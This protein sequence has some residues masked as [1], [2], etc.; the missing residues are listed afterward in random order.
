MSSPCRSNRAQSSE[1]HTATQLPAPSVATCGSESPPESLAALVLR[2]AGAVQVAPSSVERAT[3]MSASVPIVPPSVSSEPQTATQFPAP[4]VATC[5][6]PSYPES[7]AALVL[8]AAG[9]VQVAPASVERA[10]R[11]S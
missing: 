4:S 11:M 7:L 5:G 10:T 6:L 9:A 8:S 2:A 1:S 3:R